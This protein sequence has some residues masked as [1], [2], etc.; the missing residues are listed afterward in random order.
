MDDN[1]QQVQGLKKL[2]HNMRKQFQDMKQK[3]GSQATTYKDIY[4]ISEASK[5][6]P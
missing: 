2:N 4:K 3:K 1:N 6:T 5:E